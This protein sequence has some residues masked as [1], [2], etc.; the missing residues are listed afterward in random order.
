MD[1]SKDE[2][3][4]LKLKLYN[5][6]YYRNNKHYFDEYYL[7][8]KEHILEQQKLYISD[9][10]I[11]SKKREYSK[12]YYHKNN[13][14]YK[15]RIKLNIENISNYQKNHYEQNKEYYKNYYL[16]NRDEIV[17]KQQEYR[18]NPIVNEKIKERSRLYYHEHK[19]R[20][21]EMK[22]KEPKTTTEIKPIKIINQQIILS[23]D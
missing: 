1:L 12:N 7:K 15:Q 23:F 4:K 10:T 3:K 16:K 11:Q 6:N 5:Q 18:K 14:Y 20:I 2:Q 9:P 8:N 13:N 22:K 19:K 21:N 17:K